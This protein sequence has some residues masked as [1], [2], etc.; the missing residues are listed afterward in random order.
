MSER[1]YNNPAALAAMAG[2]DFQ[3]AIVAATPGGIEAQEAAGQRALVSTFRQ[4]PKDMGADGLKTAVAMGFKIGK[5]VDELFVSVEAPAGWSM[6][7]T[8][9]SMHNNILDAA[10]HERGAVFYKAAF[11][12]RRAHGDWLTRYCIDRHYPTEDNDDVCVIRAADRMTGETLHV[13]KP[14]TRPEGPYGDAHRKY[15]AA[16]ESAIEEAKAALNRRFP[17]WQNPVAYW[18]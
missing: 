15:N 1:Q 18:T 12:D 9:H 3:N 7:A 2:G 8:G 11:Y 13:S 14:L 5:D 4:L 10:G 17:D 6:D 16:V